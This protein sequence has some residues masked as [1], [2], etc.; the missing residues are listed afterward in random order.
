[1]MLR[2]RSSEDVYIELLESQKS[3]SPGYT[4]ERL[5]IQQLLDKPLKAQTF[6]RSCAQRDGYAVC[7]IP[8][9]GVIAIEL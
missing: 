8:R 3:F 6:Y 7:Q 5:L 1:M 9:N 2:P 4:G